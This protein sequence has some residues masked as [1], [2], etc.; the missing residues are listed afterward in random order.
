[1]CELETARHRFNRSGYSV[2]NQME[3]TSPPGPMQMVGSSFAPKV[4]SR[5]LHSSLSHEEASRLVMTV[6]QSLRAEAQYGQTVHWSLIDID[7]ALLQLRSSNVQGVRPACS[8][9][10]VY[11]DIKASFVVT[12]TLRNRAETGLRSPG[13]I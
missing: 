13:R 11:A 5:R 10:S 12:R 8:F 9:L 1:M 7:V 3:S 4:S 2:T 6:L